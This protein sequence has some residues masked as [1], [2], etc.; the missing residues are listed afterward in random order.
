[1]PGVMRRAL[2]RS[3]GAVWLLETWM[4]RRFTLGGRLALVALGVAAVVG[5]DTNRTVA[6]QAFTFLAAL[7]LVAMASSVLFRGRFTI[8]RV[9]PRFGTA[10][11][12]LVYRVTVENR[13]DRYQG[14]LLLQERLADPRPTLEEFR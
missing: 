1:M 6:Y 14:G 3:F 7:L 4:Y 8:R 5:V 12:P 9:L 10:G 2:L 11:E 13:T